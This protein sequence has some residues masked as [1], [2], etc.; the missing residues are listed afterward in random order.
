[1]Y[2]FETIV[3]R[4]NTG[5][6]KWNQMKEWK[7]DVSEGV[8][9][10]SVADMEIKNPPEIIDGLK[11]Y[12]DT[13]ILGY[14]EPTESYINAVCTWMEKRHDWKIK[15]EWIVGSAGVVSAFYSVIRALSNTEDGI[16][17]MSPVY[18]PFYSAIELNHRKVV[19]SPLI[20]TC[21]F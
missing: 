17:I 12:L 7:P 21:G 2:D 15:P 11:K 5:S 16:I 4:T 6:S 20:N 19:K 13:S 10:F 1:M 8:I 14:T 18:Y 9:P 3:N